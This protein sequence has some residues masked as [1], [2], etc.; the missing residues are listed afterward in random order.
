[1]LTGISQGK[2]KPIKGTL[3]KSHIPVDIKPF[4]LWPR[5]GTKT[6]YL[7]LP[8]LY[9]SITTTMHSNLAGQISLHVGEL[10]SFKTTRVHE[11]KQP[12]TAP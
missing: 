10:L 8:K 12:S 7:T 11:D 5:G 3:S 9:V 4:N 6:L 1:M 2:N